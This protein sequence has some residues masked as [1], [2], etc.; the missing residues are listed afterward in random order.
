[1]MFEA[2]LEN[3]D[4]FIT[5]L[6]ESLLAELIH[7]ASSSFVLSSDSIF[8]VMFAFASF[9]FVFIVLASSVRASRSRK[10]AHESFSSASQKR[11]RL[12]SDHCE[13]TLSSKWL[14]DLKNA[15]CVESVRKIEHLLS[16]LYYLDR[17]I[18]KKTY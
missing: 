12:T 4:C 17:Q 1:M 16:G 7:S 15:R 3:E 10:R 18:C 9:F 5:H 13:C 14:N 8:L 11:S 6:D 2:L